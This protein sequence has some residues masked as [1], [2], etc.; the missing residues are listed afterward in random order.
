MSD[1]TRLPDDDRFDGVFAHLDAVAR[2]DPQKDDRQLVAY[3]AAGQIVTGE[4]AE[5]DPHGTPLGRNG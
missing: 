3:D 1:A 2:A 5:G 4:R